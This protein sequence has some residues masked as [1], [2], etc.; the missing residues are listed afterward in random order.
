MIAPGHDRS[1]HIHRSAPDLLPQEDVDRASAAI[2]PR[3]IRIREHGRMPPEILPHARLEDGDVVLGM[4]S[5]PVDDADASVAIAAAVD[6]LFHAREGFRG[7]LAVQVEHAAWG[8]VSALDLSKL[9]PIDT[10]RDV[11]LLR[12]YA[13]VLIC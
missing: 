1:G 3:R 7:R 11:S 2:F 4:Q 8:V 6:E 10:G 5:S 9:A 12:A 13:I